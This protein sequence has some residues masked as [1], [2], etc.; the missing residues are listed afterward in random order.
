M[1]ISSTVRIAG[2]FTGNGVTTT[3]P[4]SY[5][6]FST[7]DVQVVRLTISTGIETTLTIVTDY[8]ITLNGDQDSNPGGSIVLVAALSALYKLTATSNIANLQPTDLTNQG[9][10]YPEVI[11]DA[12]DRATIQIQQ[13]GDDV[14]RSIKAPLS[15]DLTTMDMTLPVV[16]DRINKLLAFDGTGMPTAIAQPPSSIT[17]NTEIVGT[18]NVTGATT[19]Q[20]TLGVT[21]DTT[22]SSTLAVT[23]ASTLASVGVTGAATVGTTLSV[24][25]NATFDTTTLF[26]DA[27]NNRV[28]VATITPSTILDVNGTFRATGATTLQSTL[29]VTGNLA[30]NTSKFT[31]TAANGNIFSDGTLTAN[32]GVVAAS[33]TSKIQPISASVVSSYLQVSLNPTILDF[34]STTL[35]SG[36]ITTVVVPATI[37]IICP[38]TATLGTTSAVQSRIA[39]I[40]I[41]NAGTVELALVNMSGG[42]ELDETGL[43]STTAIAAASN[44]ATLYYSTTARTSVA[45]RLVGYVEST[46]ATAG[47]WATAPSTIQGVG[48]QAFSNTSS[49][50]YGQ[51]FQ[52]VTRVSGTTY[53]NTTGKPIF[54]TIDF[55]ATTAPLLTIGGVTATFT[56]VATTENI[57]FI[58][59]SYMS[60]SFTAASGIN[61]WYE[62]R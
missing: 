41:N 47:T 27:T 49:L 58:V 26:V 34:R 8:N 54:A 9:G 23:G 29:G 42:S 44:S 45:Y 12:L 10:F 24:T 13:M 18:L 48:G 7:A 25:G 43:I 37:S 6:V 2:P 21:G 50:G 62:L 19:L 56:N 51:T 14:T 33:L 4:F 46:Q 16:A 39:V 15:D 57:S 53:Y 38:S 5:K 17:G 36:T 35:G 31:V 3:F 59:P 32:N 28:G 1:T 52:S 20:T 11:T 30:V 61:D 22:L 60:Y 55:N 40:A